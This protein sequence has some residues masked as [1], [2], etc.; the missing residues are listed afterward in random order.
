MLAARSTSIA[1]TA[2]GKALT[3]NT[4]RLLSVRLPSFKFG[5]PQHCTYCGEL[6]NSVDHVIPVAYQHVSDFERLD[7]NGPWTYACST[8][9]SKLGS[10]FFDT[11]R[12]RCQW[13]HGKLEVAGSP[14]CWNAWDFVALDYN[15]Q[16]F[17]K[18]D[19]RRRKWLRI[20]ADWYGS[21]DFLLNI[22]NL[23]WGLPSLN[24]GPACR[25][26]LDYF[27][28]TVAEIK[29]LLYR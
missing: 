1:T 5:T 27:G 23:Q 13:L 28:P 29:A 15:L 9:N 6:P 18:S 19:E 17:I 16:Q 3:K 21:R 8:C 4:Q 2:S 26:L 10:N 11:F 12:D 22:E 24:S 7:A 14:I 25:F 20:R